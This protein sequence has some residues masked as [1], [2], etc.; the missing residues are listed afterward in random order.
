ML[1]RIFINEVNCI[2]SAGINLQKIRETLFSP[3]FSPLPAYPGFID[4]K[5]IAYGLVTE[6]ADDAAHPD[7]AVTRTE[8]LA[9]RCLAELPGVFTLAHRYGAHR[10]AVVLGDSTSG[11][12]EIEIGM[13]R[14]KEEGQL[15]DNFSVDALN[16]G[17]PA[18]Y[19]ARRIG[20]AGPVYTV[21]NACASGAM[22]IASG[23][24][25]IRAG[26]A[27]VVVAGGIDGFSRFTTLGFY[28]LGALSLNPCRPFAQDRSGI[29][30]GE[31]GALVILSREE[32]PME[33]AGYGVTS[34]A[35]HASAP[36]P[37][38]LQASCAMEKA[39]REARLMQKDIDFVSA[40]GT[41]TPL[42]DA[43]EAKAVHRVLGENARIASLKPYTGH[44]LA[45]AGALQA[46]FA[47]LL[48][49]DNPEGRL[50]VNQTGSTKDPTLAPVHLVETPEKLGRPLKAVMGNAFAFGGSN[51]VLLFK[52][53]PS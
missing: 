46:A 35:H 5:A 39:L 48:L 14:L 50:F 7:Y 41:A 42:N 52:R 51:A 17:K 12:H 31:G 24:A 19:I 21:S 32:S 36:H 10:V 25:L 34:D 11:M 20:A 23:A 37:E 28:G 8:K 29:N 49:T 53:N 18:E 43:M 38:G 6:L 26:L 30:L 3:I 9:E 47:W 15:P 44:T 13:K 4:G 22:A 33:L 27:D 1:D 16:L 40:H 45:G 2:T